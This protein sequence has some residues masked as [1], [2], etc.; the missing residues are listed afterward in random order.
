MAAVLFMAAALPAYAES[1]ITLSGTAALLTQYVDRGITN[2]AEKPAVQPEFDLTYKEIFYAGIWAS[3]V[4]FGTGPN[5]Q[6]IATL[7]VDYY[8]GVTPKLGKWNFDIATYY[9]A[10]PGA[11]DPNGNFDYFELWSG[12]SRSLFDDKLEIKLYNYWSPDYFGE[13]GNND[14]LEF[15]YAW[16]FG[17]VGHVTPKL[18]GNFGHQWGTLSEGGYD[19]TYW[20]VA[21]K[22]GFNENPPARA[23]DPLLGFFRCQGLHLSPFGGGRL[24]QSCCGLSQSDI[25]KEPEIDARSRSRC[26]KRDSAQKEDCGHRA[27]ASVF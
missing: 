19:Y 22:L 12:V 26:T 7:E 4:D 14:V 8:L 18:A 15:S 25:L 10:Y 9:V 11:F 3:N 23:R 16:T 17:K 24:Q 21:L 2:S 27:A 5:G 13:T 6:D 20:S 1:D